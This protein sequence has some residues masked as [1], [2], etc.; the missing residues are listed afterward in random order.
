VH[1]TGSADV[2]AQAK[3]GGHGVQCVWVALLY[4]PAG[5]SYRWFMPASSCRSGQALPAGQSL[6]TFAA[7]EYW[8]ATHFLKCRPVWSM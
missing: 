1:A 8:P 5:Q 3:P 7:S 4:V 2:V 6:Q